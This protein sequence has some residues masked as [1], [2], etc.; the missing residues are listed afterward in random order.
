MAVYQHIKKYNYV[1]QNIDTPFLT[2]CRQN[3]YF[4]SVFN[5]ISNCFTIFVKI[6]MFAYENFDC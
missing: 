1:Y 3:T 4:L 6:T 5:F 2:I